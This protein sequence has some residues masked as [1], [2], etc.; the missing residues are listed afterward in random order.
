MVHEFHRRPGTVLNGP[1]PAQP[2]VPSD[3]QLD[4]DRYRRSRSVRS[5]VVATLSTLAVGIVLVLAVTSTPGWPRIQ[6]SFFD[7][8]TALASLPEVLRGLWLNVRV[9][10]GCAVIVFFCGLALAIAR[11]TR[12][13]VFAP[14]RLFATGYTDLFRGVP[15]ILVLLLVGYGIPGLRLQG[16]PTSLVFYG[17]LA[18][19]LQ[20]S[21]FVAEVLRAG[22]E[23]VH[24]SQRASARSLGLSH[25][26]TLR[27]VVLP[28]AIRRVLPPWLNDLVSL[29]KDSRL[30]SVLGAIDAIQA[31]RILTAER[32]DFTPY[33]VAGACFVV[34][35]IPMARFTDAVSRR[36]GY[37]GTGGSV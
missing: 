6:G 11:T 25:A 34:L 22:I 24:P 5:T 20:Y 32:G 15:L 19:V 26:Q 9:M 14:L 7:P 12:G 8:E 30:I 35:T 4:R 33:L 17:G 18:L 29:Q 27:H 21:A 10:L 31:A 3:L 16:L 37:S 28:Q 13:P 23:S 36:W 2:W 1:S